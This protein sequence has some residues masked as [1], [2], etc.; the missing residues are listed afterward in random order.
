MKRSWFVAPL[1]CVALALAVVVLFSALN[2]NAIRAA[3]ENLIAASLR[4][5]KFTLA[6]RRAVL[7]EYQSEKHPMYRDLSAT[8]I[9][10][11]LLAV[12][13]ATSGT[14]PAPSANFF[15]NLTA[16][17]G[18]SGD[19]LQLERT[20]SCSLTMVSVNYTLSLPTFTYTV[21]GATTPNYDQI[22][23]NA[24]QLKTNGGTWPAGCGDPILG[25]TAKKANF[26]GFTKTGYKVY[27]DA[28]YDGTSQTNDIETVVTNAST[29]VEVSSDLITSVPNPLSM[30]GAD[31]NGDGN[32][33]L[34]ALSD[35][36]QTGQTAAASVMLGDANGDG[37]FGS[38]TNYSLPGDTIEGAVIDDFNGDGK[39]DLVV[40]TFTSTSGPSTNW[41]L[42]FLKGNG[43]G[44]FA[45]AQNVTLTPPAGVSPISYGG[46][47]STSLRGNG[48]KDLVSAGG[49]VL[50][51]NGDGTFTQ[52]STLAF[53]PSY[54]TSEFGPN[55]VAADFNKD[56]KVDLAY[57]DGYAIQIYLG[58]GDGTFKAGAG[59]ATIDNV[60]YVAGGD[61][62]GDGNQDIYS[63]VAR[64]GIF[65]GDQFEF[66]QSYAL[67]GNGDGTFQGAPEMPFAFTGT[68]LADLNGDGIPDGVG[69][70]ATTGTSNVTM[71][72][73]IGASNGSFTASQTFSVSPI[74]IGGTQF[75]FSSMD[76]FGLGDVTGSGKAD[77]VYLPVDFYGPGG[78]PGYFLAMGNGDGTF[79]TPT[80]IAAPT[81][82]P[83]GDFDQG[84]TISNLWVADVN[85]DGK[86]DLIYTY[87]LE[88]YQT[89]V[90]EQGI[91][92]QLSN[93]DGT[94]AAPQTIQT[95]SST[96]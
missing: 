90:Y 15:G 85:G 39:P 54:G 13:M 5:P 7:R 16:I 35:A 74:T 1:V 75:Q 12:A 17:N 56:G 21:D 81:F 88:V 95:Y 61:L 38:P 2:R 30:A 89:G 53:S 91:A 63:G 55:L 70:N 69:V 3:R 37:G 22:L 66:N 19:L 4:Y 44:T 73:Y 51:G 52:S 58:N 76:S 24:A 32:A 26:I 79:G 31:L 46:L 47:I 48:T 11:R 23:H 36:Y 83:T 93:G 68:N 10:R 67:M 86:A 60:G 77:L 62:D 33:D 64:A 43:D 28:F 20:S 6:Q 94:F 87:S 84:E 42:S 40:T 71:T 27:G 25:M 59:Y 29:D 45:A 49:I 9:A 14:S 92:V 57:D 8:E 41:Y 96:T 80:F 82:A 65:G 72:S 18:L 34:V 78:V 50:F